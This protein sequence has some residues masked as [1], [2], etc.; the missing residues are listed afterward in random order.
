MR[1]KFTLEDHCEPESRFVSFSLYRSKFRGELRLAPAPARSPVICRHTCGAPAELTP[2]DF[3]YDPFGKSL[4][5]IQTTMCKLLRA[6]LQIFFI[7][8]A[9]TKPLPQTQNKLRFQPIQN[10]QS[11]TQNSSAFTLLELLVAMAVL[12]LVLVFMT[13]AVNGVLQSTRAQNQQMDGVASARKALDV[14]ESDLKAAVIDNTRTILVP[15]SSAN[16]NLFTLYADR[17]GP[18]G[19]T[20][21]RFLAV[22]YSTNTQRELVR[23]YGSESYNTVGASANVTPAQPLAKGILAFQM[24]VRTETGQVFQA[25]SPAS[26]NWSTNNFNG[27]PTANGFKALIFRQSPFAQSLT[28]RTAAL[29]LWL[30]AADENSLTVLN[31]SGTLSAIS[32]ALANQTDPDRWRETIDTSSIPPPIKSNLR[33]LR[34]SVPMP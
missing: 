33:I 29:E 13:Q 21:H 14:M 20:G 34:K 5:N 16:S 17:R 26:A 11:K 31:E 22:A 28:N 19:T 18:V 9:I 4:H 2:Q 15:D 27:T 1:Q 7:H 8:S 10:P 6:F 3:G 23:S 25:K 24:R 32:T 12:A 30:V